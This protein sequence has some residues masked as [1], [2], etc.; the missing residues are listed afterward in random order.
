MRVS[1][2]E[3]EKAGNVGGDAPLA[4]AAA[5]AP[6]PRSSP[7]SGKQCCVSML[8]RSSVPQGAGGDGTACT[9]A[10]E[11]RPKRASLIALMLLFDWPAK[12]GAA[13]CRSSLYYQN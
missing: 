8:A 10:Q 2:G 11:K 9:Q 4:P 12:G 3:R 6:Q 7:S 5:P 13:R 1:S